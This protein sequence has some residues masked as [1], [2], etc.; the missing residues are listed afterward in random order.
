MIIIERNEA[1]FKR[2]GS[3][4]D[5]YDVLYLL[6]KKVEPIYSVVYG[7]EYC[8][9]VTLNDGTFIPC[10]VF[11]HIGKAVRLNYEALHQIH[12]GIKD[13]KPY[14]Q[15]FVQKGIIERELTAE[16][17]LKFD[18]E[19]VK[20]EKCIYAMPGKI[21]K[22][23]SNEPTHY[24]LV[25]FKDGSYENF[26][27]GEGLFYEVPVNKNLDDIV[28]IFNSALMLQNNEI[29]KL[30]NLSD[31]KNNEENLK[32]I[33]IAKPYFVCYIGHSDYND[34]PEHIARIISS[35]K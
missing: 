9:S 7:D 23:M 35:R 14:D 19:V 4:I 28:E 13:K 15:E 31:W 24:F 8:A 17:I 22:G 10:V 27:R 12:Y 2:Y 11:R 21:V 1:N 26:R 30:K 32:K 29:I 33:H 34:F 25:R 6:N 16:N 5:E 20:I 3:T 18:S